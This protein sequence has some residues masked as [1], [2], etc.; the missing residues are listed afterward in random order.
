MIFLEKIKCERGIYLGG[1]RCQPFA[2]TNDPSSHL[3]DTGLL[4]P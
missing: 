1:I 2:V 3:T 4:C